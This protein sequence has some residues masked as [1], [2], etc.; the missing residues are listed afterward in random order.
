MRRLGEG[1]RFF[2]HPAGF[3]DA[4][5]FGETLR[6]LRCIP[7]ALCRVS[8]RGRV[9]RPEPSGHSDRAALLAGDVAPEVQGLG[10]EGGG[11]R[12]VGEVE[13]FV[14]EGDGV[15][16]VAGRRLKPPFELDP[17]GDDVG[18]GVPV[19]AAC[20]AEESTDG[21]GVAAGAGDEGA[22]A[23]GVVEAAFCGEHVGEV[24][25][26]RGVEPGGVLEDF[27]DPVRVVVG[28]SDA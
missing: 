20:V 27:P 8:T 6:R 13:G 17:F 21:F 26:G 9:G 2:E 10:G 4:A 12:F 23:E 15:G 24:V 16:V 19:G 28:E 14:E 1:S 22:G 7:H 18:Q 3:G 11:V 5:E 25:H